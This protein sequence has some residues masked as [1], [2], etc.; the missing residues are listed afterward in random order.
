MSYQIGD[1]KFNVTIVSGKNVIRTFN[2]FDHFGVKRAICEYKLHPE[3]TPM[4]NLC[5]YLFGDYWARSEYEMQ[6]GGLFTVKTIK[7]DIYRLFIEP[8]F[9][10]LKEMVDKVS[11]N[12]C[13]K[14]L[15]E[16]KR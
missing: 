5:V 4:A 16:H 15:K 3:R 9:P 6:V 2:V 14:W 11:A 7:M 1:L 12:S 13:K 10:L 8:N